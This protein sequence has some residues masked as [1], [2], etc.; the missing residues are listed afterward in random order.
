MLTTCTINVISLLLMNA[1]S[2][3]HLFANIEEISITAFS[4]LQ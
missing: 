3:C 2:W 1:L 4:P